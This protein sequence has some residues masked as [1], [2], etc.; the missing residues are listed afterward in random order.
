MK[1][2]LCWVVVGGIVGVGVLGETRSA[3]A[4]VWTLGCSSGVSS[5]A[6]VPDLPEV[7]QSLPLT[8]PFA[9]STAARSDA[10]NQ[11]TAAADW[12]TPTPR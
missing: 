2:S 8:I 12:S 10:L 11:A 1:G 5:A 6:D 7:K 3:R 9:G 4:A